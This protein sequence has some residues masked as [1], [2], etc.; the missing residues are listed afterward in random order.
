VNRVVR[1]VV[2]ELPASGESHQLDAVASHHLL[3]VLRARI[4]QAVELLDGRGGR[5]RALLTEGGRRARLE[6]REPEHVEA[7]ALALEAW[8]PLIKPER[9]EWAVEKLTELGVVRIRPYNSSRTG[10]QRRPPDLARWIRVADAALEQSGNPWRPRLEPPATLD[11]HLAELAADPAPLVLAQPGSPALTG[12]PAAWAAGRVAL[13]AGP[14][15]GFD[16]DELA[17]IMKREPLPVSLGPHV[18]RAETALVA[19]ATVVRSLTP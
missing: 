1:L 18:V 11:G 7:P 4:G 2:E 13:L 6:T 16:D 15:G 17:R 10:N 3:T 14:E 12:W 5:C 8:L 9:M 19:L